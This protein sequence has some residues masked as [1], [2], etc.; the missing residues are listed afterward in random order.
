MSTVQHSITM[1]KRTEKNYLF[2][3]MSTGIVKAVRMIYICDQA[4]ENWSYVRIKFA[5]F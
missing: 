4:W 3:P 1:M 2:L 5:I